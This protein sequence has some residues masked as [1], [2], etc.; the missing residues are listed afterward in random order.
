MTRKR[1]KIIMAILIFLLALS[2]IGILIF[3][4]PKTSVDMAKLISSNPLTLTV[5]HIHWAPY[6]YL[7]SI[8]IAFANVICA[9]KCLYSMYKEKT[10]TPKCIIGYLIYMIISLGALV[11]HWLTFVFVI[12]CIIAG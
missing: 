4:L 11:I 1:S 12:E 9:V 5:R 2:L 7:L 8:P 10:S 3:W 6:P